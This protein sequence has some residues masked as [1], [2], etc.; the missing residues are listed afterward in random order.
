MTRDLAASE[1]CTLGDRRDGLLSKNCSI[2]SLIFVAVSSLGMFVVFWC[3]NIFRDTILSNLEIKEGTSMFDRWQRPPLRPAY[4]VRIFNYTNVEDFQNGRSKKL[5]VRE[6]GPYNYRETL[7]RVNPTINDDGTIT[8]QEKRS[9][10][11]EGGNPDDEIVTVP[12]VPLLSA[13]A[14]CR[15]MN[16]VAQVGVTAVLTTMQSSTF[17]DVTAGGFLWGYDDKIFEVARPLISWQGDVPF[18]KFGLLAIVRFFFYIFS[19]SQ[20]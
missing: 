18:E 20:F 7:T 2:G 16:F 1:K 12:N 19:T 11:W 10:Q 15:D 6:L 5:K 14:F 8:Y 17:I 4:R 9:F 13:M 3:T